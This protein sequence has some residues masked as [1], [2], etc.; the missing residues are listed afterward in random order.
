MRRSPWFLRAT[1]KRAAVHGR[2]LKQ[3]LRLNLE[4]LED[5]YVM[6]GL[7][8]TPL[9]LISNPDPLASCPA[10]FL[11]SDVAV[12]TTIAVNPTNLKNIVAEWI[13]H[14]TAGIVAGASFDGG[15]SWQNVAIPG[16]TQCTGG[17][18]VKAWDPWLSFATNG[19]LYSISIGSQAKGP[20]Q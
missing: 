3:R 18:A 15:Q 6:S 2:G 17:T 14:G 11:G 8:L 1:S 16:I 7:T 10:G 13:D 9:M 5:R 19:D 4:T 20:E 12:E